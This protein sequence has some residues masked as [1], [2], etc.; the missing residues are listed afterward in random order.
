MPEANSA[1]FL[2]NSIAR[3][4]RIAPEPAQKP[5]HLGHSDVKTTMIYTHF[6]NHGLAGIRS[7]AD[8]L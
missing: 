6:L 1:I 5:K 7:L 4:P 8:G 2:S 3:Y